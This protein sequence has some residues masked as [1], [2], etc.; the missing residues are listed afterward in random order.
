MP[1][2]VPSTWQTASDLAVSSQLYEV[3]F[4]IPV[5]PRREKLK[6]TEG[7]DRFSNCKVHALTPEPAFKDMRNS[8]QGRDV[9]TSASLETI[10]GDKRRGLERR[11]DREQLEKGKAIQKSKG[12]EEGSCE[13]NGCGGKDLRGVAT[14]A[15]VTGLRCC[16]Y[17]NEQHPT[18]S[19]YF[20]LVQLK[21]ILSQV[22][23]SKMMAGCGDKMMNLISD[24]SCGYTGN[25]TALCDGHWDTTL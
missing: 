12:R 22:E 14:S 9:I 13:L 7:P 10:S 2:T 6:E 4:V 18:L 23:E 1:G 25:I 24:K 17:R 11:R 3:G 8:K 20:C 15:L 19:L 16:K 21:L 5:S